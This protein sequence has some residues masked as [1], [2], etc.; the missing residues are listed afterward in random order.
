[1]NIK[2]GPMTYAVVEM[3]NEH[4]VGPNS[5][6]KAIYLNGDIGYS[7]L[8]IRVNANNVPDIKLATMWHEALHGILY[9]SG[10][11]DH[12]EAHIEALTYGLISFIRD[13]PELIEK[14]QTYANVGRE[15]DGEGNHATKI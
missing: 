14:T 11:R 10:H 3:K 7:E 6:G 2:I 1:M 8:L 12:S 4:M 15:I 13:N 9:Q 5:E